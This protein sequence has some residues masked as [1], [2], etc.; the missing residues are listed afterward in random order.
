MPQP[1]CTMCRCKNAQTLSELDNDTVANICKAVSKDTNQSVAEIAATKLNLTCFWIRHQHRT[2]RV[3]RGT[4]RPLVK[5]K[6]SGE[7]DL[8]QEQ[9]QEEDIWAASHMKPEY[10]LLTLDISTARKAFDK[11]KTILG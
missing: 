5:V 3:I 10:T 6:Y 7:I 1:L 2:S 9:K 11:V 4:N 8:L